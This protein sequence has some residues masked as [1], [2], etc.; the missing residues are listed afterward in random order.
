MNAPDAGHAQAIEVAAALV[1]G[2]VK[3]SRLST[4][5]RNSRIWRVDS[6]DRA[7]ALK[8]DQPRSRVNSQWPTFQVGNV[9]L[10]FRE[11]G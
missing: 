3:I 10:P 9:I 11:R 5:G 7:F 4:G 2:P 6:G 1:G 8:E